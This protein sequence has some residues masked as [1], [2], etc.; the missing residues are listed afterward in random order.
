MKN[1]HYLNIEETIVKRKS[2]YFCI[3]IVWT[4]SKWYP[5]LCYDVIIIILKENNIK[6]L[7]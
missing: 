3:T 1:F 6:R 5:L 7:I 4:N 2:E